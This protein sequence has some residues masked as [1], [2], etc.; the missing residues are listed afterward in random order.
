MA[1]ITINIPVEHETWVLNGLAYR[2]GYQEDV[3]NPDWDDQLS[4]DPET[5][6]DTI[7]NPETK[8]AFAKRML[9][10]II[11]DQ[12]KEGYVKYQRGILNT[13]ESTVELI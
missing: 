9:I 2:F 13:E 8:G 5:N 7:P 10:L 1:T 6:P 12:A 11:K 4:T 3:P